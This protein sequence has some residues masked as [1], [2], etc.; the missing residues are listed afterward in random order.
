MLNNYFLLILLLGLT[1]ACSFDYR[2]AMIS[3][4]LEGGTPN[5]IIINLSETVIRRGIISYRF[6]AERAEAF[7]RRNLTVFTNIQFSEYDKS[8]KIATEG[9]VG[10]AYFYS[11]TENIVFER[12]FRIASLQQGYFIKGESI[13]WAGDT[14]TLRS[15]FENEVV[16]GKDDGSHI[17]GTGFSARASDNSFN[18]EG[19]VR[20]VYVSEDEE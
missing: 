11:D 9:E 17:T 13:F 1:T 4:E 10:R 2:E 12:N 16:M 20:G 19:G 5:A 15:D 8:G 6:E 18:F 7:E 14:R 3:E